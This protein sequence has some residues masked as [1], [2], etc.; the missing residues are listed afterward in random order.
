MSIAKR[1][2][3]LVDGPLARRIAAAAEA[4]GLTNYWLL[5]TLGGRGAHG[6]WRQDELVGADAKL[7]FVSIAAPDKAAAFVAAIT[8][9]LDSHD[10]LLAVGDVEVVRS[11]QF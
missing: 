8:P 5:P 7:L 4:A 10:L 11:G 3:V 9:L 2:E 1:I 6:A